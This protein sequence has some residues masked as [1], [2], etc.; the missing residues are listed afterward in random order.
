MNKTVQFI[1]SG[2]EPFI[3]YI[4][5]FA[6]ICVII[7]HT[8][9]DPDCIGYGLWAGMQ[10]PLFV[11]VQSFHSLKKDS[12]KFNIRKMTLR[13]I[14]PFIIVQ[15]AILLYYFIRG[16]EIG[17]LISQ[18]LV[19]GG[20]GPGAYYPWI[21]IQM[22]IILAFVHPF[23]HKGSKLTHAIIAVFICE[24]FEIICSLTGLPDWIYRLLAVRYLFL[25]FLAWL[26]VNE[27]IVINIS[28][29]CLAVLSASA[30]VYFEFYSGNNEPLFYNTA[31]RFHRWPC[32]YYVS[33]L[34]CY[35]I[36]LLYLQL[37]KTS[38]TDK[39]IK[40]ISKCSYEIFLIQ[41][42]ACLFVPTYILSSNS[43]L[44][45]GM[46]MFIILAVSI[47]GGGIFHTLYFSLVFSKQ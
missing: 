8:V 2:Y 30:I 27:G 29:L 9:P 1:Q 33:T 42:A 16:N 46:R 6:I 18:G 28:T 14:I 7:G 35:L 44:N 3:D 22:A 19:K 31:W 23:L 41:M 25:I 13:V 39:F 37:R 21:Y 4:K 17:T 26:W 45:I 38:L 36:Y 24:L 20:F 47:T 5:A 15:S 40:F 10:V 12:F 34:L 43:I 11:L 32:Y